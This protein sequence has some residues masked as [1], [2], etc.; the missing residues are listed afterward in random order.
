MKKNVLKR[1]SINVDSFTAKLVE[2]I[3]TKIKEGV[4]DIKGWSLF[5]E[6]AIL[7]FDKMLDNNIKPYVF[8]LF[9][10]QHKMKKDYDA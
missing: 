5:V 2:E 6:I 4:Y 7:V 1:I 3:K 10:E 9:I 8:D